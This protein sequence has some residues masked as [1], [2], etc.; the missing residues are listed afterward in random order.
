MEDLLKDVN[1]ENVALARNGI[2]KKINTLT[3]LTFVACGIFGFFTLITPLIMPFL[4]KF[5][6]KAI[7]SSSELPPDKLAELAKNRE[8]FES[9][10][11]NMIPLMVIGLVGIAL[12]FLGAKQM[13][14]LKKDG[15]LF[16]VAGH[17]IPFVGTTVIMGLSQFKEGGTYFGIVM[18]GLFIFLYSKERYLL[19]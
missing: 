19:K 2:P 5:M 4:L 1:Y 3:T 8:M 14:S 11:T 17:I 7:S 13:R 15:F 6:D 12:R 18:A 10:V 9:L 16:Y